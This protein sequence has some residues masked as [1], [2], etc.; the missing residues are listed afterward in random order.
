MT[1]P[2][3]KEK[4]REWCPDELDHAY[5]SDKHACVSIATALTQ[6]DALGY[7]RGLN[8]AADVAMGAANGCRDMAPV[9]AAIASFMAS[10][11]CDI[12]LLEVMECGHFLANMDDKKDACVV[13]AE[14]D[15][16][17]R[18]VEEQAAKLYNTLV[19]LSAKEN[20]CLAALVRAERAE[21]KLAE[22]KAF[23]HQQLAGALDQRDAAYAEGVTH[24]EA[25][26][27]K[28]IAELEA[29]AEKC[30]DPEYMER[31]TKDEVVMGMAKR[32]KEA[33]AIAATL[34]AELAEE[35]RTIQLAEVFRLEYNEK[36]KALDAEVTRLEAALRAK[37]KQIEI[38]HLEHEGNYK[39]PCTADNCHLMAALAVTSAFN[40]YCPIEEHKGCDC[41]AAPTPSA[42]EEK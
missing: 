26:A 25:R 20:Q 6:A 13:C 3:Y 15:A 29:I 33:E 34:T 30:L 31:L 4:A 38:A 21:A 2:D 14:R 16:L 40:R 36:H 22:D 27:G 18:Q 24:T 9:A 23:Y 7:A 8:Y 11:Y 5:H 35:R 10:P 42:G 17:R 32:V 41:T 19:V 12:D 37:D 39:T 1:P 28:R